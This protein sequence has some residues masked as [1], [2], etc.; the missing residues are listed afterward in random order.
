MK[1]TYLNKFHAING[2]NLVDFSGWEMPINYGSQINEHNEVRSNVGI[3]DVSHMAVFDFTGAN[4]V[5]FLRELL[6]NDV[7]KILESAKALYSPLL[8]KEGGILDD[9][10]VYHLGNNNFRII[11]NCATREQNNSWF[12]EAANKYNVGVNFK[13]N[14]SIIAIQGPESNKVLSS[15]YSVDLPNFHIYQDNEV[16]IARTGYTGELGF[17]I[18]SNE[19]KGLEI[20]N[21]FIDQ[22]VQPIGLAARDTLRLEAGLN[23]YG[24]D[25]NIENHPYESNLAWTIDDADASRSYIGKESLDGKQLIKKELIG[26][27]TEE[28][29]V[30][31]A[32]SRIFFEGGEGIVTSGTYSP[33]FKKNIGLCRVDTN[34]PA[35]GKA[36]LRDKEINLQFCETNFLKHLK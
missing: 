14:A 36:L 32:G 24:S 21:H 5:E 34:Y 8:N 35:Q 19:A 7:N 12:T 4:Q 13:E 6:P 3:F 15:L 26:F 27:Y 29:G 28:R 22:G 20:W 2:G 10:I 9:L 1:K 30:L 18:I 33:T 25:M 31:R 11:S 17:E 16:M 23:L